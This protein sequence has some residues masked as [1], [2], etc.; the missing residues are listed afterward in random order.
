MPKKHKQYLLIGIVITIS[1]IVTIMSIV[2]L[3]QKMSNI[4]GFWTV[5]NVYN[6]ILGTGHYTSIAKNNARMAYIGSIITLIISVATLLYGIGLT[7]SAILLKKNI[8]N[9]K[10]I[11]ISAIL[12]ILLIGLG[13]ASVIAALNITNYNW[14]DKQTLP[15][16]YFSQ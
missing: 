15:R 16:S 14:L 5:K 13:L 4:F 7:Y 9:K 11:I 10:I 8:L 1:V 6:E 12:L 3:N 2:A